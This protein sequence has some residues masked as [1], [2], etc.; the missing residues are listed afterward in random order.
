M[1]RGFA[2][3]DREALSE[4]MLERAML[5]GAAD[6]GV[7]GAVRS[8]SEAEVVESVERRLGSASWAPGVAER[9]SGSLWV[10]LGDR[11]RVGRTQNGTS[12]VGIWETGCRCGEGLAGL[13]AEI[14]K[15]EEVRPGMLVPRSS[16]LVWALRQGLR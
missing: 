9:A 7:G 13:A 11:I 8:E 6:L 10:A 1:C 5:S 3:R 2:V 4:S 12:G 15:Y 16:W 14:L